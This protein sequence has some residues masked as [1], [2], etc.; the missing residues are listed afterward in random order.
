VSISCI[1]SDFG[2]ITLLSVAILDCDNIIEAPGVPAPDG[3]AGCICLA[4][5]TQLRHAVVQIGSTFSTG[6]ILPV[7]SW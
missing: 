1:Y 2:G 7:F 5:E 4:P 3:S 6:E